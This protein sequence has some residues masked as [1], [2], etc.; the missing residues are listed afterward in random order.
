VTA[1]ERGA[2]V[3]QNSERYGGES[4]VCALFQSADAQRARNEAAAVHASFA[5]R[6][7][8]SKS[9]DDTV[10]RIFHSSPPSAAFQRGKNER[11]VTIMRT[12]R[13]AQPASM[14]EARRCNRNPAVAAAPVNRRPSADVQPSR[15]RPQHHV[16]AASDVE[17][18]LISSKMSAAARLRP[19][20]L[21]NSAVESDKARST[22]S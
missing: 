7:A 20:R 21:S 5:A 16:R 18:N 1:G 19:S 12:M 11:P 14:R 3:S 4:R 13:V 2:E 17:G 10:T 9:R 15:Q 8:H 6:S 22:P